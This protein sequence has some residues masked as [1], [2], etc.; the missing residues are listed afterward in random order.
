MT[1]ALASLN[2]YRVYCE[3]A[4]S[5]SFSRAAAALKISRSQVSKKVSRLERRLGTRLFNRSTRSLSLTE[6]G[7]LLF[8][9]YADL[10]ARLDAAE[11]E[12]S[13]IGRNHSGV[14]RL[15]APAAF[16][17]VGLQL[18]SEIQREYPDIE[19]HLAVVD[20]DVD[21]ID[22]GFDA[23][24][25]IGDLKD[26]NLICRR[27]ARSR[28]VVCATPLYWR[29]RGRPARLRELAA[30]NCLAQVASPKDRKHW[31]FRHI[32]G[33]MSDIPVSG[34]FGSDDQVML[35]R[36]CLAGMGVCQ[37]PKVLVDEYLDDGR[38]E[39][40][41]EDFCHMT[42]DVF[43]VLPHRDMPEKVRV[44]VDY[45]SAQAD[46]RLERDGSAV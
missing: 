16:S 41:L 4:R 19:V 31:R 15:A 24:I 3:V 8:R 37:L 22:A 43:V 42:N 20:G 11:R 1:N 28:L 33:E 27:I 5:R 32:D 46:R 45:L 29:D 21:I 7:E 23:A 2:E 9:R 14:I 13:D 44:V 17:Y 18:V 30:H 26:S 36:A 10:T 40:E 35:L 12:V 34:N 25:H 39:L 6:A 38:L